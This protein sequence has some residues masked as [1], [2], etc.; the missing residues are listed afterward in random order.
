MKNQSKYPIITDYNIDPTKLSLEKIYSTVKNGDEWNVQPIKFNND[1]PLKEK[2]DVYKIDV[3]IVEYE[4]SKNFKRK[5]NVMSPY[6]KFNK[7]G[8][9]RYETIFTKKFTKLFFDITNNYQN[10]DIIN[11][12]KIYKHISDL[13]GDYFK[14]DIINESS[15]IITEI[16]NDITNDNDSE[17]IANICCCNGI[18]GSV[19]NIFIHKS[20]ANGGGIIKIKPEKDN[21]ECKMKNWLPILSCINSTL[22]IKEDGKEKNIYYVG[23]FI[24]NFIIKV[25]TCNHSEEE[26]VRHY[27][28]IIPVIKEIEIKNNFNHSSSI[29]DTNITTLTQQAKQLKQLII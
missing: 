24:V 20:K 9:T 23:K 21:T 3:Y 2:I 8:K 29:V 7:F 25:T 10:V 4:F 17:L 1:T 6:M 5:F 28:K 18:Y 19:T 27:Y 11:F 12:C 22:T 26:G 16:K 15:S 13:V 14:K